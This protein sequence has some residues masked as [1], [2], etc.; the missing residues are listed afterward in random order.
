MFPVRTQAWCVDVDPPLKE[1]CVGVCVDAHSTCEKCW[2]NT[3]EIGLHA[4]ISLS[5]MG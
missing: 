2:G 3:A 1:D 5:V 4:A